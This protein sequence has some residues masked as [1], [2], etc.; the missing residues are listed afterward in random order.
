MR[1]QTNHQ[2]H[3]LEIENASG[4]TIAVV[5]QFPQIIQKGLSPYI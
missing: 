3:Y 2:E 4:R 1:I 5:Q